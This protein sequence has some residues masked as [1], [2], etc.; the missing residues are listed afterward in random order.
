MLS[1]KLKE[2]NYSDDVESLCS[3]LEEKALTAKQYQKKLADAETK[4]DRLAKELAD[5]K[6]A[7][8]KIQA[9]L[10][11]VK[12]SKD[13]TLTEKINNVTTNLENRIET[14]KADYEER[15]VDS[16]NEG[17]KE[18]VQKGI[19]SIMNEY[20]ERRLAELDLSI[21][22][23]T[24]ALLDECTTIGDVED[25]LDKTKDIQR[26]NALHSEPIE[27][28]RISRPQQ[29]KDPEQVEIDK[30]VKIVFQGMQ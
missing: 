9:E 3:K 11:K 4:V 1:K 22:E 18:G 16:K 20:I 10:S 25:T 14:I 21:G 5:A 26:R 15:L 27:G 24:R 29:H 28:I 2:S 23:N 12:E 6:N 7:A 17:I 19:A 30:S 13:S 8:D